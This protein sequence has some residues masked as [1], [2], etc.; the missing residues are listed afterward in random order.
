MIHIDDILERKKRNT[1]PKE[2]TEIR[3]LIKNSFNKLEFVED[4]HK[5]FLP[6]NDGDKEELISVSAMTKMFEQE[7]DWDSIAERY[8]LNHD[9]PIEQVKRMWKENNLSATSN[10]SKVHMWGECMMRLYNGEEEFV[11]QNI[12]FL[13][14]EGFMIPSCPKEQAIEKYYTDIF[15]NDD[16][17][18]IM[19]ETKVYTGMNNKYNFGLNYAGTFDI[20]L[21]MRING[22]I[23]ICIHD[24]KGLP[25]DTPILTKD[26]F[27]KMG[28]LNVGDYVFDKNGN[29]TKILNCSKIHFNPCLKIHFDDGYS[30]VADNEHRWLINFINHGKIS[31]K[32]MTTIEI[33]DYLNSVYKNK[34]GHIPSDKIPKIMVNKPINMENK[35]L[36]IDPYVLGVWLGD[37]SSACGYITNMYDEIFNEIERRGFHVGQDVS[38]NKYCGKAKMRCVFGLSQKL[39]LNNILKNKHIPNEYF[40]CSYEQRLDL[41]RGIMDTDGYYNKTRSRFVIVTSK[42]QIA[43]DYCKLISSLGI[44][45]TMIKTYGKC[46]NGNKNNYLRWDVTFSTDIYP[47]L[48]RQMETEMKNKNKSKWRNISKVEIVPTIATRCIEVDSETHTFLADKM[49]LVTHNTNHSLTKDYNRK[50]NINLINEFSDYVDEPLSHYYIQLNAYQIALSQLDL[51][52]V[53]RRLIWLKDDGTYEKVPV[54]CITDRLVKFLNGYKK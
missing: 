17:Y 36:P 25:L 31:E 13:Y 19:P 43:D 7:Q 34:K 28:D 21:A 1:E 38:K 50:N 18:P 32:I 26:G 2:V 14:Q 54:P 53:D 30:I 37:G 12:P 24:F 5:Y 41:L 27:K 16:V 20:L 46:T 52:I 29:L 44:K 42:K 15:N 47:F 51:P 10:G 45:P 48:I 11:K 3:E 9:I 40:T 33:Y 6:K 4:G 22:Q 49:L 23:K 35:S 8:S 39:K